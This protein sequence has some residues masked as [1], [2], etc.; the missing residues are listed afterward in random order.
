MLLDTLPFMDR[1][2][3][4]YER[5]GFRRRSAYYDTPRPETVFMELRL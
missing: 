2:I 4:L 1:A 3:R 5:L